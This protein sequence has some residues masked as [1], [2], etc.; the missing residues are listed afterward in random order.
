MKPLNDSHVIYGVEMIGRRKMM[1]NQ[2]SGQK[3]L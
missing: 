3:C 2:E 1:A